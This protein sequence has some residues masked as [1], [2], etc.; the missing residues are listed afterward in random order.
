MS[1]AS[2]WIKVQYSPIGITLSQIDK[3][4]PIFELHGRTYFDPL[5][6]TGKC[7]M[8]YATLCRWIRNYKND[9]TLPPE[10]DE[11]NRR[12]IIPLVP[13]SKLVILNERVLKNSG[14][15]DTVTDLS[16]DIYCVIA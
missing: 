5:C 10:G 14:K 9:N 2:G 3:K 16:N 6:K 7:A 12:G 4:S 1:A 8:S 15:V 13:R 11:G